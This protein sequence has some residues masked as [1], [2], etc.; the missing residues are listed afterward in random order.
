MKNA[1]FAKSLVAVAAAAM[2]ATSAWGYAK[3]MYPY[4]MP[5]G[6]QGAALHCVRAQEGM[7]LELG[8]WYTNF[9]VCKKYADDNGIPLLAVWSNH[10]CVHCWYTD[11]VFVQPE[12]VAWQKTHD[13][14][15][16]ICCYMAGGDDNIDQTNSK[17]IDELGSNAYNW[18]WHK[19][20]TTINSYPF[21]VLWWKK[22]GVNR[23]MDGDTF[24]KGSASSALNFTEATIPTRVV[25]VENMLS[26]V[27]AKWKAQ[28]P[29]SGGTTTIEETE[30]NRLEADAGTTE[31]SFELTRSEDAS[32]IAT[33]NIVSLIGPDGVEAEEVVVEWGAGE[34]SKTV[35]VDVTKVTFTEGGQQAKVVV[36]DAD[37]TPQGTNSITYV[38]EEN[39][40]Y[41]PLWIGERRASATRDALPVLDWGEWTMD[42]DVATQKVA[43][44]EGDAY[45][46]VDISGSLWCPDCA[47]LER[48]F[49]SKVDGEGRNRFSEWA[50][51]KQVA[52]VAL[53]IPSF[54]TNTVESTRPTLLS[55][56]AYS[57]TLARA[58]EY[59]AS[60]ADPVL[61]NAMLRSGLGYLTR[62]GVSDEE[63]L[64]VLERNR[65][66]VSKNTAEGG[67]HRPEDSNA[68]RTGVPVFV[69]LR[70]DGSVAARLTRFA[71]VSPMANANWD[72]I[73]K[74]FDELIEIAKA[75][76]GEPHYE[77]IE[78]ND[79]TSTTLAFKANGGSG[80]GEISHSDFQDVFELEGV[81]GNAL[82]KVTVTGEVDA[83]VSV[84]FVKINP[85]TGKSQSVGSAVSGRLSDGVS[86][87]QTFTEAGRYFVKVS[88]GDIASGSFAVESETAGNFASFEISGTVVLVPQEEKAIGAAPEGSDKVTMRVV[89]DQ[90]YRIEGLK[91]AEVADV[92]DLQDPA[93][94]YNLFYTA[95]ASGDVPVT[96]AYKGGTVTHQKW[97]PGT[98]GFVVAGKSVKETAGSVS[99]ALARIGGRSGDVTVRVSLDEEKTT[100]YNSEGGARFEF[101]GPIELTWADGSNGSTNVVVTVLDD[102]RFDGGGVVALKLEKVLDENGDTVL[103][104]T[105]FELAVSD[106]DSQSAGKAAF[107]RAEPFFS[108]KTTVYAKES[109]GA[110]VYVERV[111]ASDGKVTVKVDATNGATLEIGGVETDTVTW[112]NHRYAEQ[113]VK[114]TGLA[115][116]TSSTLTLKNPTDGLKVLSSASKV[117]VV[118]VADDA[119]AFATDRAT[120]EFYRFV[121]KREVYPVTLAG[122]GAGAKLSFVKLSGTLPAG[123]KAEWDEE[124]SALA[125]AGAATA[126][127][128][129]YTVVYQ[130]VQ[131]VGSTKTPG[132]TIELAIAVTDPTD[133]ASSPETANPSVAKA[134]TFKDVP[135]VND[136]NRRLAGVLQ[137]T[138]PT[139]GNVSAKYSCE[140]GVISMSAKGWD[141]FSPATKDLHATAVGKNGFSLEVICEADGDVTLSV[142]D[143]MY[144]GVSLDSDVDSSSQWS[145]ASPATAW[146]GYYTVALVPSKFDEVRPG[147]AP[148]GNGFLT[149]KMDTAA[150]CSAGKVTWAGML[151]NGAAVSGSSILSLPRGEATWARLPIFKASS[152]DALSVLAKVRANA[153][154]DEETRAVLSADGVD[155]CWEHVEKDASFEADYIVD[156]GVFGGLYSTAVDLAVCCQENYE[157]TSPKLKIDSIEAGTVVVGSKSLKL[158]GVTAEMTLR[159][160][161]AT[162]VVAGSSAPAFDSAGN[163]IKAS[164]KGVILQGWGPGCGC[165]PGGEGIVYLP[166][167]NG[168]WFAE[169]KIKNEAGKS[170][171]VK[172]GGQAIIE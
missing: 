164:W 80:E 20:G 18:M 66:L 141:D 111:E 85:A 116:G 32:A 135:V 51:A 9:E 88:G 19:G 27:F 158:N 134:R 105:G 91:A 144:P 140:S 97:V 57:S 39:S 79:A 3:S 166:F 70:K 137:V 106:N 11:V 165:S 136:V 167:M 102:A 58:R 148:R 5:E 131:Q 34:T 43:A 146:K 120:A 10:G 143:P 38:E 113:A 95:K 129:L 4:E 153:A 59:P 73:I 157:T 84:Q 31:V 82:Q 112:E 159:L 24:C 83:V 171:K 121:T 8:K 93:D 163:P 53:D 26:T 86:L 54:T 37:G 35:T 154:A 12:F 108:K 48:N 98:I 29:Y 36:K 150:A 52:F 152:T 126:K 64:A 7:K 161:L 68:Y 78:N 62:K 46:L 47:N 162:G 72:N 13:A 17:V 89:K 90:M 63:A 119:P 125:I 15:K 110:T 101:A 30:G 28:D 118:A 138:I 132:L 127:A 45:T 44:A 77:D 75:K 6:G 61:T 124:A 40:A 25:N 74:R 96:T 60:G 160:T 170:L 109:E 23:R 41:N 1:I 33:N 49:T 172:R 145:K 92:F 103:T 133:V 104:T 100:L 156:F 169:E 149:L 22:E 147:L 128:G 65:L 69:M 55:R 107:T 67:F 76:E 122:G 114:V 50:K 130:A 56:K 115:A 16:I 151:P 123:L 139:K 42:I 99:V 2:L 168:A 81:G 21:V 94:P 14:G 71:S 117:T 155:S 87:E 142:S